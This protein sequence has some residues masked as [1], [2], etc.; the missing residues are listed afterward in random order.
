[1]FYKPD[2]S[3]WINTYDFNYQTST[4]GY[5]I[6]SEG[7]GIYKQQSLSLPDKALVF[8]LGLAEST[9]EWIVEISNSL[10]V[11]DCFLN[12]YFKGTTWETHIKRMNFSH[13]GRS[14]IFPEKRKPFCLGVFIAFPRRAGLWYRMLRHQQREPLIQGCVE[15]CIHGITRWQGTTP[16]CVTVKARTD[17]KGDNSC[18]EGSSLSK[19]PLPLPTIC[20]LWT[21]LHEDHPA[22]KAQIHASAAFILPAMY[23]L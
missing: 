10:A 1:M 9:R 5:I 3:C 22:L 23:W 19:D 16:K 7:K 12:I 8:L 4:I 13:G 15:S 2:W 6:N 21:N 17:F 18:R 11:E 20:P 14:R